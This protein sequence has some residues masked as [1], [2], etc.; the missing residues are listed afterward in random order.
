MNT[1]WNEAAIR[2]EFAGLDAKTGL[3]GAK[4]PISFGNAKGTLGSYT[5]ANEGAFRFSDTISMMLH[6]RLKKL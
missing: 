6:G 1:I 4:L 2:R 3:K 5:S